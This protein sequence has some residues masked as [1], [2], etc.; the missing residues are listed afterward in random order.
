MSDFDKLKQLGIDIEN[1]IK[2]ALSWPQLDPIARETAKDIKIRTRLGY[3]VSSTGAEREPLKKLSD[4]YKDQRKADSKR[5]E[6]SDETAP[7]KSNLT[8]TGQMLDSLYGVARR[9]GEIEID[10]KAGRSD[11]ESNKAIAKK[12]ADEGRP[13]INLSN[14]ELE[15]LNQRL[16]DTLKKNIEDI[17]K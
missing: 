17:F 12:V 11:G 14:R 4:S 10:F 16:V 8:R 2:R 13:F 9:D 15:R 1:A 5:G 6:L 3:G 7:S